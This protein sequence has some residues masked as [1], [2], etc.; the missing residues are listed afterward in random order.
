MQIPNRDQHCAVHTGQ[1]ARPNAP[2]GQVNHV[3][4]EI[5]GILDKRHGHRYA[6]DEKYGDQ[7]SVDEVV[8]A[9]GAGLPL[10]N[11]KKQVMKMC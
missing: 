11:I 6:G 5:V 3:H 1:H 8:D 10:Y 2:I 9:F 7:P 4:S